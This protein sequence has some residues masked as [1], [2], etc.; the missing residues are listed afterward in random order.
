[1]TATA[2]AVSVLR[3]AADPLGS[4]PTGDL[5]R[6]GDLATPDAEA[7]RSVESFAGACAARLG[8]GAPAFGDPAPVGLGP[9]L[10]AAAVGGR[11]EP[12][13]AG[14]LAA[15]VPEPATGWGELVARHGLVTAML[16][17]PG[18][19]GR[20]QAPLDLTGRLRACSPLTDVLRHPVDER[21]GRDAARRR[22]AAL[23]DRRRGPAVLAA[24]LARPESDAM[25][26]NW[27]AELLER[28]RQLDPALMLDVYERACLVHTADWAELNAWADAQLNRS[29]VPAALPVAVL[30]YWAPLA[31]TRRDEEGR[32]QARRYTAGDPGEADAPT[33]T[34]AGRI[35]LRPELYDR[36]LHQVLR[37]R[38]LAVEAA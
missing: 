17:A 34:M 6:I 24:V 35:L 10:M 8:A 26:L 15:A 38:L 14:Q 18:G 31:R 22:F 3:W 12:V 23:L 2:T 36:V 33:T 16:E 28:L 13:L 27:R 4:H 5:R 29:G 20:Q 30:R 32:R 7:V 25:T 1:M 9:L 19:A 11:F 21:R 37:H